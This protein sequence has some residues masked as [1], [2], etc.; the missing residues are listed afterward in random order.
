[1]SARHP[2]DD[3]F[4]PLDLVDAGAQLKLEC[5][6]LADVD[7]LDRLDA[8]P[9]ERLAAAVQER[10]GELRDPAE[11]YVVGLLLDSIERTAEYGTNI[12]AIAI[13]Q[14]VRDGLER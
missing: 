13:Q 14:G 6:R 7:G 8:G 12:A 3:E 4:V 1:M 5:H 2:L 10:T 11:A 9:V